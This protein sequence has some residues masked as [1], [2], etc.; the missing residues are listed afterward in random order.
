M[1]Y[2]KLGQKIVHT[3]TFAQQVF[4]KAATPEEVDE[5]EEAAAQEKS[6]EPDQPRQQ[7]IKVAYY[8]I[9]FFE[10]QHKQTQRPPEY[11]INIYY[12]AFVF[13]KSDRIHHFYNLLRPARPKK[14]VLSDG[15]ILDIY[16]TALREAQL[17]ADLSKKHNKISNEQQSTRNNNKQHETD[18]QKARG[19][20]EGHRHQPGPVARRGCRYY[21]ILYMITLSQWL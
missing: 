8:H 6:P 13:S 3:I 10:K 9:F 2:N 18:K 7:I 4:S 17:E 1:L 20:L 16:G 5:D 12:F 11:I 19:G 14:L 21:Y 15:E